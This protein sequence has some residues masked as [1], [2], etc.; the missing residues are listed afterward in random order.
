MIAF[1]YDSWIIVL[2]F[3]IPGIFLGGVYDVF[4]LLRIARNDKTFKVID[5]IRSHFFVKPIIF[6]KRF[7]ISESWI[8]FIEDISFFLIVA[9]T[10]ILATYYINNGEIRIYCLLI[11][12]IGFF[13]YQKTL[14]KLIIF[15]S[16][17]IL[18][19]IRKTVYIIACVL[20]TPLFHISKQM[21]KIFSAIYLTR[22]NKND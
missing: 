6:P 5:A 4:R 14:G 20:L 1:F 11:S 21:K 10:E 15:F 13:S 22:K 19:L 17:K 12:V 16:T 3:M 8:V 2:E 18:Y 9:I 7:K